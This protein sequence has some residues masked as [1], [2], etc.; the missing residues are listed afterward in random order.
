MEWY[1]ERSEQAANNFII[2]IRERLDILHSEPD[3]YRKTYKNFREITLKKYPYSIVYLIN[4]ID[5][6]I[7]ISSIYHHKRSPRY[8]YKKE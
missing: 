4:E 8:K 6:V 2:A 1:A 5:K 3:R 7:V